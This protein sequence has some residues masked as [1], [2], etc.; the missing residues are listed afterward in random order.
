MMVLPEPEPNNG[1]AAQKH[2]PTRSLTE[3]ISEVNR[4]LLIRAR[5]Y[6]KWI[7][8]LKLDQVD[9]Q[10]RF[11]RLASALQYLVA[12]QQAIPVPT[13]VTSSGDVPVVAESK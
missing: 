10:D 3:A 9:A 6:P 11:D 13:V 5:I 8:E 1:L 4:E 2:P 12:A 7:K